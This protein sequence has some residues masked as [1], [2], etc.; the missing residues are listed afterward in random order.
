MSNRKTGEFVSRFEPLALCPRLHH[1]EVFSLKTIS[2]DHS[3]SQHLQRAPSRT[4]G[5]AS[6]S[7]V[8]TKTIYEPTSLLK[9]QSPTPP[10]YKAENFV[11]TS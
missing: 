6:P 9:P 7:L 5:P 1:Y 3:V 11:I 10:Q 8:N 4:L 2:Q